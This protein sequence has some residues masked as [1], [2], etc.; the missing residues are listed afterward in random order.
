M[1][2]KVRV[3]IAR[4]F[5]CDSSVVGYVGYDPKARVLE[6]SIKTPLWQGAPVRYRYKRVPPDKFLGLL[7]AKSMGVYFNTVIKPKYVAYRL[8][9]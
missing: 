2:K 9:R 6:V 1:G 3:R 7:D 8:P 4:T 5:P